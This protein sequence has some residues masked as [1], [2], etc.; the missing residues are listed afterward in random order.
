MLKPRLWD[1]CNPYIL[2]KGTI[3]TEAQAGNNPNNENIE[4]LLKNC[5]PCTDCISEINNTQIIC[6]KDN[7]M[8]MRMYNL[9]KYNDN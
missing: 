5:T 4:V 1:Y 3:S 2:V 8:L 6:A 9:I 7:D